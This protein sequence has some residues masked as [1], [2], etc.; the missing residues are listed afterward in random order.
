VGD[1]RRE[2]SRFTAVAALLCLGLLAAFWYCLLLA[3]VLLR[4][5]WSKGTIHLAI[6]GI[7]LVFLVGGYLR[8]RRRRVEEREA[9]GLLR[10][11]VWF[12]GWGTAF[13]FLVPLYLLSS[14]PFFFI[15]ECLT[16]RHAFASEEVVD[17]AFRILAEGGERVG[18]EFLNTKLAKN[19]DA[20]VNAVRLLVEMKLYLAKGKGS[21]AHLLRTIEGQ[22][23][24][25][26]N[27]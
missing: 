27:P 23:F 17:M 24:L 21:S 2:Y 18:R 20:T 9:D 14:L 8:F 25:E 12:A 22:E 11:G 16:G 26:G 1:F 4:V 15:R 6:A 10:A 3:F 7:M 13:V 19:R 5:R